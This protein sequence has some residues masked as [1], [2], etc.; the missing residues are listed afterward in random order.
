[1]ASATTANLFP[2]YFSDIV[3][4]YSAKAIVQRLRLTIEYHSLPR[5]RVRFEGC[6][7]VNPALEQ[8]QSRR[9]FSHTY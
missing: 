3:K 1:M 7:T 2:N 6:S 5:L 9:C 8:A 4:R